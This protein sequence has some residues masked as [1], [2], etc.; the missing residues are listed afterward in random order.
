MGV[1]LLDIQF[2]LERMFRFKINRADWEAFAQDKSADTITAG[3]VESLVISK[4]AAVGPDDDGD[5]HCVHCDYNLRG[6]PE[7]S[8]CPE[9]GADATRHEQIWS[10]VRSVLRATTGASRRDI[11]RDSLLKRDLGAS[12]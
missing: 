9:C 10:G 8:R 1:D 4:L 7:E 5:W 6:L 2:R 3:H 11:R 12:M